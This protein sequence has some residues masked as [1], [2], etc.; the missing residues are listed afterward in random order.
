VSRE[1]ILYARLHCGLCEEAADALRALETELG[2]TVIERDI[3]ADPALLRLYD[4]RV[5][6]VTVGGREVAAAP[7][8]R[9]ALEQALTHAFA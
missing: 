3:D 7:I 9:A 4:E 8:D 6:V 1:V 5:P 2:F